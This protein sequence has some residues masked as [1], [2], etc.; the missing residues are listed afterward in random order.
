MLARSGLVLGETAMTD[1]IVVIG[2]G[3]IG[4]PTGS[5]N[6]LLNDDQQAGQLNA[7]RRDE[8]SNSR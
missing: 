4:Q 7:K 2:A 1:V 5:A 8:L 6:S 3:S